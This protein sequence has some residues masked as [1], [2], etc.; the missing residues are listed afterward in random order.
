MNEEDTLLEQTDALN[1]TSL[2]PT[3]APNF[4]TYNPNAS[5]Y[6]V[7]KIEVPE[8]QET[9]EEA[10]AQSI[11]DRTL[12]MRQGLLGQSAFR[13]EQEKQAGIDEL[14]KTQTDLTGRLKILQAEQQSIPIRAEESA[15]GRGVTRAGQFPIIQ[16]QLRQ[17][18]IQALSTSALLQASQGQLTSALQQIDRAV[19]AKYNPI[20][21]EID[22]LMGNLQLV[23]QSPEYSRQEKQQAMR[24]LTIQE[25]RKGQIEEERE[26]REAVLQLSVKAAQAGVDSFGLQRIQNARTPEQ[27]L[28][29]ANQFGV[30][31]PQDKILSVTEAKDLGVPYGTTQTQAFGIT[32]T[33]TPSTVF[34]SD[35]LL[36]PSE[37]A[38]LG[39]PYGT[40]QGQASAQ[41][42]TPI[43][44][45]AGIEATRTRENALSG[46]RA[47]D[48]VQKEI[49]EGGR[50]LLAKAV[51]P[52]SPG[53][54]TFATASREVADVI[55][56][57]RTGAALNVNEEK[58]YRKQI[59]N[60]LDSQKTINYK[61]SLLQTLF[62][63]LSG[64]KSS[65][66]NINVV[67]DQKDVDYLKSL[68]F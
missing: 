29:L 30:F 35:K 36:S 39:V 10:K 20:K 48:V 59:P 58:F 42:I 47:L 6:D 52:F 49:K 50:F 1:S 21:E 14:R 16:A 41:G 53:A 7:S 25:E 19:A 56:R 64:G 5:I 31:A 28:N 23:L 51:L 37:A 34:V 17:N 68:G 54:R 60:V 26:N 63:R 2:E 13:T 65:V 4:Q 66:Q 12:Q 61:I 38:L 22:V 33:R 24:Q 9:P 3:N 11:V 43:P 46:L 55:T 67:G 15:L 27:A 32:P 18:A 40:T 44:G 45:Q 8:L 57:L 62:D